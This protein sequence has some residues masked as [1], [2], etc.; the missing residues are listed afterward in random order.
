MA[1]AVAPLQVGTTTAAGE[2]AAM[3]A[4]TLSERRSALL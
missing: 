2:D 4:S 1:R 3:T